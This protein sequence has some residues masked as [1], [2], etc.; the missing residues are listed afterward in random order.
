MIDRLLVLRLDVVDCE[1]EVLMN[2]MPIARANAARTRAIVPVHEYT[3]AGINR[4]ELVLWPRPAAAPQGEVAPPEPRVANGKVAARMRVLLPRVGNAADESSARTLVQL[5]WTPADG[6]AYDAPLVLSREVSLPVS[7]PR[8]RWL[9]APVA[10]NTDDLRQPALNLLQ[11]LATGLSKGDVDGFVMAA[12]LRTEEL[13]AAYQRDAADESARLRAHL[14]ECFADRRQECLPIDDA[15]LALRSVAGGR[16]LECLDT[17]GAPALRT[18]VDAA[19]RS[20]ALP[21]RLAAVEGR[22]YVLR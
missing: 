22:L 4:F 13:A 1:A 10:E 3:V 16:L 9:D 5:E 12:R 6:L 2:G 15:G 14:L 11:Q 18:A 8:W 20:M 7:F 17:T 21:L 19:G